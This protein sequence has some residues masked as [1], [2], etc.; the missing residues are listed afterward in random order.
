MTFLLKTSH[1]YI[2]H[3]SKIKFLLVLFLLGLFN[4]SAQE[5]ETVKLPVD[6][7]FKLELNKGNIAF[8]TDTTWLLTE[9]E[10]AKNPEK[11]P[12]K[13]I[14]GSYPNFGFDKGSFWLRFK[15][16]NPNLK[17]QT[18]FLEIRNP[19]IDY[20]KVYTVK[21]F[22]AYHFRTL[23]DYFPFQERE[24]F[25]RNYYLTITLYPLEEREYLIN[26]KNY[27]EQCPVPVKVLSNEALQSDLVTDQL[28]FG[29][30]YGLLI[31]TLLFNIFMFIIMREREN[32][33]YTFYIAFFLLLQASLNGHA[34]MFLWPDSVRWANHG[35][36]V[37][38]SFAVFFLLKFVQTFLNVPIL[39]PKVNKALKV[40]ATI[41]FINGLL[42]IIYTQTSFRISVLVVNSVTLVLNLMILPIAIVA[43]RKKVVAAQFFIVAFIFL[44]ISVFVF[45]MRNFGAIPDNFYTEYSLLVGSAFEVILLSFAIIN[46]FKSFKDGALESLQEINE[47]KTRANIELEIQVKER[48]LEITDKNEELSH[49]NEEILSSI[50][51]ASQIQEAILP[52]ENILSS[53]FPE[54]FIMF[55]PR[56]IVSGDFYWFWEDESNKNEFYLIVADCTG[57]GV[58]GALMSMLGNSLLNEIIIA[59]KAKN[60]AEILDKLRTGVIRS[61]EQKGSAN[62]KRDGMDL[63]LVKFDFNKMEAI[64]AGANNPIYLIKNGELQEFKADKQPIGLYE[65]YKPF[66]EI[67]VNL[68]KNDTFYLSSDGF[69]DQFGGADGK[70]LKK[71]R[72]KEWLLEISN[73]PM[74]NQKAILEERFN[75]WKANTEQTDDVCLIG[76]R[77]V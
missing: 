44:I 77:V 73:E 15:I 65:Y 56:D 36:P 2:I 58:P 21:N 69:G 30:Y 34:F 9:N 17:R 68:E 1:S 39:L 35:N 11:F 48:T 27:G 67:K 26:V 61:F 57:H 4:L 38:A 18:V 31:F 37:F 20:C 71:S 70:K 29:V 23:G 50:R 49:K 59:E 28:A 54:S 5:I 52:A 8:F 55:S 25:F 12:F 63:A 64:F 66:S 47:M 75:N 16:S 13:T 33:F 72:M 74:Q 6:N 76:V 60:P 7:N 41:L 10:I 46:K 45:V 24:L 62:S 14:T 40:I 22:N 19:I 42:A 32:F 51:Y 53:K 3:L 43:M